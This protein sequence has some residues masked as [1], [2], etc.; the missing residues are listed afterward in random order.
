MLIS[1]KN[2][3]ADTIS[4]TT[5]SSEI[6]LTVQS[7]AVVIANDGTQAAFVRI[8]L[9]TQT[10]IVDDFCILGGQSV[11]LSKPA[12]HLNVAAITASSTTSI[13]VMP[14]DVLN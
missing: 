3:V 8:G 6:T 14:V 1:I 13:K 10:A 4:A 9:G 12:N 7:E 5:T 11:V 2:G